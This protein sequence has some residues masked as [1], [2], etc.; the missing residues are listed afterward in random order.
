MTLTCKPPV[1]N[2][3][4]V[5]L[6]SDKFVRSFLRCN[7][8]LVVY[9]ECLRFFANIMYSGNRRFVKILPAFRGKFVGKNCNR[10]LKITVGIQCRLFCPSILSKR[11]GNTFSIC[12]GVVLKKVAD[13][14]AAQNA[15]QR[16]LGKKVVVKLNKGRRKIKHYNGVVTEAHSNV[17]VVQLYGELFDRISCSY[18]DMLCGEV[19]LSELPSR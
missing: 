11:F 1:K 16:L 12:G 13:I 15:V 3:G 7:F 5:F 17:F 6:F 10:L 8:T 9:T 4:F 19:S 18:T 2:K 14:T